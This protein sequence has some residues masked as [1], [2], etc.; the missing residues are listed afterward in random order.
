MQDQPLE[1]MSVGCGPAVITWSDL[2]KATEEDEVLTKLI[3]EI[4]RGIPDSSSEMLKEL[5]E[6]HRYRHSLLVVDG[7]VTY[8]NRLVIPNVLQSR[9]LDTLHAAHQGVSSMINRVEQ[10]V[11]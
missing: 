1:V 9:V 11:F 6:F 7:V 8:K 2:Q 3:E 4:Q 10:S 5:R